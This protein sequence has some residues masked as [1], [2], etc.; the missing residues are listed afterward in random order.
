MTENSDTVIQ[1]AGCV[2][3][4]RSPEA[5]DLRICLVHRHTYDESWQRS[6]R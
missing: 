2:L 1:A 4:R 5:G 3:W 6:S